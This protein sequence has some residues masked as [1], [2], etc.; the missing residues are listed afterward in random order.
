MRATAGNRRLSILSAAVV[1]LAFLVAPTAR[2]QKDF[3][4]VSQ[5]RYKVAW[6]QDA[7]GDRHSNVWVELGDGKAEM[8]SDPTPTRRAENTAPAAVPVSARV[9]PVPPLAP[10]TIPEPTGPPPGVKFGPITGYGIDTEA[11][12]AAQD[13]VRQRE[14]YNNAIGAAG[15]ASMLIPAAG[16]AYGSFA[17]APLAPEEVGRDGGLIAIAE[18]SPAVIQHVPT[19]VGSFH[20]IQR[21]LA[22]NPGLYNVL[23]DPN[24]SRM[25][26]YRWM[27]NVV[28]S[29]SPVINLG[30][31][32]WTMVEIDFFLRNGAIFMH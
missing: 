16:L 27:T 15:L 13:Y 19:V 25:M 23:N 28:N 10:V 11:M 20:V 18:A 3:V 17:L 24:W 32:Y 12:Q 7:N 21:Y 4:R 6:F 8:V 26:Q 14:P 9:S 30:G 29:G 1:I 5:G 22:Q 2:P 31:N